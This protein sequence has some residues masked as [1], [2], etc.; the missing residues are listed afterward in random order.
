MA[1]VGALRAL[2]ERFL[3]AAASEQ[4]AK[5]AVAAFPT[6]LECAFDLLERGLGTYAIAN[7][8]PAPSG[9][10]TLHPRRRGCRPRQQA[11]TGQRTDLSATPARSMS[12]SA[13]LLAW[14]TIKLASGSVPD[15]VEQV[16]P[17]G[18][19]KALPDADLAPATA[20]T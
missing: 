18:N 19:D 1:L 14:D 6:E 11:G 4:A 12:V 10:E 3:T 5:D 16:A 2:Y 15:A 17:V 7:P 13:M 8:L 20:R 9:A